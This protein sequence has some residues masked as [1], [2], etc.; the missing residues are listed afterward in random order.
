[1]AERL[2]ACKQVL[3]AIKQNDMRGFRDGVKRLGGDLVAS[4]RIGHKLDYIVHLL[5][6]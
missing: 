3:K 6:R 2:A 4:L 5:A 1:M